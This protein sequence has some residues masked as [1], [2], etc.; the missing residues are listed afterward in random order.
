MPGDDQKDP[1]GGGPNDDRP[2]RWQK[3]SIDQF[4][5]T[6]NLVLT[7]TVATLGYWFVLL[8]NTAFDPSSSAKCAMLASLIGLGASSICGLWCS[9]NRLKDF[10]ET[11]KRAR[12]DADRMSKDDLKQLSQRSWILLRVQLVSFGV[13]VLCLGIA[14]LLMYGEKLV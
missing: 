3:I 9:Y 4:G 7:F 6:L 11:A 2:Q 14:L 12:K 5:Y 8:T 10:R 1:N 13:G